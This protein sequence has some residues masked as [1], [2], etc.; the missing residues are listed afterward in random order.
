MRAGADHAA[1]SRRGR[2]GTN[3]VAAKNHFLLSRLKELFTTVRVVDT[4]GWKMNPFILLKLAVYLLLF[5][6]HKLVLSLN[7]PSAYKFIVMAN[8]F[9]PKRHICYFVIGGTLADYMR[10]GKVRLKPFRCINWFMVETR[11]MRDDMLQMGFENV[12]QVPNFKTINHLP[13]AS[14]SKLE[15]VRGTMEG[16]LRFLFLSR[17]I[18]EKGCNYIFDALALLN[19]EG[20][21]DRI[22]VDFYGTVPSSYR[23][24]FMERLEETPNAAYKGFIDMRNA[25]NYDVLAAYDAMLFPTYWHGEGF[26]G[27]V[28]DAFIAGLP[29][30]AS[31]WGH[32]CEV[33]EHEKTG[34]LIPTHD[35][36]ALA[37]AMKHMADNPEEMAMMSHNCQKCAW[38]YDTRHVL[39]EELMK[40]IL[41][42][43]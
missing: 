11:Q 27:I 13:A 25:R 12:I 2:N 16:G 18:P 1:A 14:P 41:G 36:R 10:S 4:D 28:I 15:G 7:T 20:C 22:V 35:V 17:I 42:K 31:D 29:V 24:H 5:R 3:G 37:D 8:T 19:Q 34:I 30:I 33:I 40:R 39:S 9:F 43:G 6:R 32:N 21:G 23:G 38:D 26:P